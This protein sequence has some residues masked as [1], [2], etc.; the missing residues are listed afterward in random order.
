MLEKVD[1]VIDRI[2]AVRRGSL[3]Q[4][5]TA[6]A[7]A[8]IAE[9]FQEH[10]SQLHAFNVNATDA[11]VVENHCEL[12]LLSLFHFLPHIGFL[13]RAR[14][15][16]NPFEVHGPLKRL[17]QLAIDSDVRL[18]ISSEWEF[19]PYT[20]PS[21]GGIPNFILLGLPASEADN[22]LLIPI[23]GHEFGH[24][25]WVRQQLAK[26][27]ARAIEAGIFNQ[28]RGRWKEVSAAL[29]L[30]DE[31]ELR[32]DQRAISARA[33]LGGFVRAQCEE[34][35]CDLFGLFV[36]GESYCHAFAHLLAPGLAADK[37]FSYPTARRRAEILEV[38]APVFGTAAPAA[39]SQRFRA[40]PPGDLFPELMS[41][42]V[43]D[44]LPQLIDA[45]ASYASNRGLT[46]PGTVG[47][48]EAKLSLERITP[49]PASSS[50]P[51]IMCAGWDLWTNDQLWASTP[52]L[53][54]ERGRL[55]ND[56]VLKSVQGQDYW[57]FIDAA[58]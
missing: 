56:L 50:L 11:A 23:A 58:P 12:I 45:V 46:V 14:H 10:R 2:D 8:A 51:E 1:R 17:A 54:N 4:A 9:H 38:A 6:D 30:T 28:M 31:A 15:P 26:R 33:Q 49:A 5:D 35:F 37:T 19:S 39:F 41:A 3:L 29:G 20:H 53:R 47:R 25:V 42:T 44:L 21:M 52:Y 40:S 36:F 22:A 24:P 32:Q 55:I 13:H 18:I 16:S 43:S 48:V 57:H 27:F 7:L 34:I